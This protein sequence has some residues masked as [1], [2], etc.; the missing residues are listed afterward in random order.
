[1]RLLVAAAIAAS[2]GVGCT[3]SALSG[4]D[5]ADAGVAHDAG[6]EPGLDAATG[7]DGGA[8]P[9]AAVEPFTCEVADPGSPRLAADLLIDPADPHPGD[10][11]VVVV[12]STEV[13]VGDAPPMT[14]HVRGA[15]GERD[16]TP[17]HVAGGRVVYYCAVAD[18]ARG[19]L[20]LEG[21]ID[22]IAE[23]ARGVTVTPRPAGPPRVGGGIYKVVTNHQ[24]TC[25]EQ[26][27]FGVTLRAVVR[28]A[29]GAPVPAVVVRLDWPATTER[30]I[31]NDRDPPEPTLIPATLTTNGEG[32]A[33][34]WTELG[35]GN[36]FP[37][38]EHGLMVFTMTVDG[39]ASDVATE[40]TTGW[41]ETDSS[42]CRYCDGARNV[43]GH[44][45][46][47]IEFQLDPAA[48]RACV[49]PTDHAGMSRCQE[50]HIHHDPDH[51]ACWDVAP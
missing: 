27:E 19:D 23:V 9:D 46:H 33:E 45:S 49:V 4:P 44:W 2:W 8:E 35:D 15:D 32:V 14:L 40:I 5:G 18:V 28:D 24:W 50:A 47:T 17:T 7:A 12:D 37:I 10:T 43:W 6:H 51:V 25:D 42:G 20:C 34:L 11:V 30:P 3:P 22:G 26:P 36:R 1:M 21:R 29:A 48:T 16:L 31:Y 13:D 38:N 39:A 41:W